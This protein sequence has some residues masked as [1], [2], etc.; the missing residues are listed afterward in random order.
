MNEL[1]KHIEALLLG[2][3][4]VIIPHFGGFV[5]QLVTSSRSDDENLFL[6]PIRTVA[7]HLKLQ[8][9]D[10]LL[11]GSFMKAY[12]VNENEAKRMV[13]AQVLNMRQ[14]LLDEG[15]YDLGSLGVLNQNQD[16][17]ITFNPCEAGIACPSFYGLDAFHMQKLAPLAHPS[18]DTIP[19]AFSKNTKK[20]QDITIRIN[21]RLLN[22]IVASVAT[23]LLFLAFSTSAGNT[24]TGKQTAN[25]AQQLFIVPGENIGCKTV[26][27]FKQPAVEKEIT[28]EDPVTINP[29]HESPTA[30]KN[31]TTQPHQSGSQQIEEPTTGLFCVVIASSTTE[32]HAKRFIEKLNKKGIEG[33]QIYQKGKMVRVIFPGYKT[34]DEAYIKKQEIKKHPELESAWVLEL[35]Q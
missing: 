12:R 17:E 5:T 24:D 9:N 8:A 13:N 4:C 21:R 28:Q 11:V 26:A 31:N 14:V 15:C 25:I 22:N 35:K 30:S 18:L 2:N 20:R 34:E 16:G 23:I 32:E 6:P 33:A 7:F 1:A 3:D 27:N 29:T 10:G 19:D